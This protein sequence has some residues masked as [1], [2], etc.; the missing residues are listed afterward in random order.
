MRTCAGCGRRAPQSEL[1]RFAAVEGVLVEGRTLPGRG[2]YTCRSVACFHAARTRR[3]FTR[4]LR[5]S[6]TVGEPPDSLYTDS[7][8]G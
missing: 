7:L 8:D 6:V 3:G 2:V 1:A 4:T 5:A